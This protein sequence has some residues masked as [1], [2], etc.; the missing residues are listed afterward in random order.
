MNNQPR[1]TIYIDM[2]GVV[3]D[4]NGFAKTVLDDY[5]GAPGNHTWAPGQWDKLRA[6]PHLY[7]CL[8]KLE[9]ADQ[10]MALARRFRDEL[11]WDLYML[12]A[13][14]KGNDVPDA[15]QD[16]VLWQQAHFPDVAVRFGPFAIDKQHHCR[17]GDILVDDRHST[18]VAWKQAQGHAVF[19]KDYDQALVELENLFNYVAGK[20]RRS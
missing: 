19:V 7:W 4:F 2:D 18:C 11:D 1:R 3:A 6:H 12:T 8:P 13:V 14:P 16:K 15:F 9:K 5:N 17:P 10:M 20:I